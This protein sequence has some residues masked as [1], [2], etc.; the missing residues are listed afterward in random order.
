MQVAVLGVDLGKNSCSVVGLDAG[1]QVVFGATVD[2]RDAETG[3]TTTYQIVGDDEADIRAGKLSIGSP[4]ARALIGK[5]AGDDIV[6]HAPGGVRE[7]EVLDVRY[8]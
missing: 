4:M 6:V 8:V 5:F 2:L 3:E 1:G 7:L